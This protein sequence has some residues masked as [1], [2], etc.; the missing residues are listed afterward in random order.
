MEE[1]SILA[2][3]ARNRRSGRLP[4]HMPGHKRNADA[5]Y[6]AALGAGLDITEIEGFDDLHDP[7]GILLAAEQRAAR[8]WGAERTRFLVG[9]STCGVLAGIFALTRPGERVLVARNCHKSVYHALELRRLRAEYLLP[10][11]TR[12]GFWGSLSPRAVEQALARCPDARLVVLTSPSYEGVLSDVAGIV[13]V[14]HAHGA[15][16]FVD[17]AH[18]AHLGFG[19]FPGGAVRAGA[20][21]VVQSLHKTLPSLTQTALVHLPL[22]LDGAVAHA[23]DIFETSSPSYLLLASIDGCVRL[24]EQEG[25]ARFSRYTRALE[26]FRARTAGLRRL[27]LPLGAPDPAVFA[28]DPGKLLLSTLGTDETGFGLARR[29]RQDH[30]IE[31]E[32]AADSYALCMTGL[33]DTEDSLT[34]LA[35]ALLRIDAQLSAG[36][37]APAAAPEL[38]EQLLAI[39]EALERPWEELPAEQ[40]PGYPAAEYLWAYPPGVPLLAP[41][42]R[43]T[44]AVVEQLRALSALGAHLVSTSGAAPERIRVLRA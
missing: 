42:E 36:A 38:P 26:A 7:S 18:G 25:A 35:D 11:W 22:A 4:M 34:R 9:G 27:S 15:R 39:H 17:E 10:G 33:G 1:P 5:P 20:D 32:L 28:A 30:G 19:G 13:R 29:L 44:R 23:L 6:L 43:V 37:A 40:A 3:L 2:L 8:L 31:P 41:G 16:V 14:A 12:A 21:V 24:L